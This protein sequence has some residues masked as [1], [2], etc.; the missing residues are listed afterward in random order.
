MPQCD[1]VVEAARRG[2][3]VLPRPDRLRPRRVLHRR[4]RGTRHVGRHRGAAARPRRPCRGRRPARRARRSRAW[5]R[6][7]AERHR[8]QVAR[9]D[10]CPGFDL[11]FSVPKSVSVALGARRSARAGR[12]D[13]RLRGRSRRVAGMAGTRGLLRAARHEQPTSGSRPGRVRHPA[14][15]RRGVRRGAVPAS[16]VAARRPAPSLARPRR[17]HRPAGSTAAGRR[18]TAQRCTSHAGRSV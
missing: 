7:D 11:T 18:S 1:V 16:H 17:Q 15:G 8:A 2:R 5:N 9:R 3:V 6:A 14:D 4:R 10:G 13:G 12:G